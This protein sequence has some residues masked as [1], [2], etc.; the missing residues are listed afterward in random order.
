MLSLAVEWQAAHSRKDHGQRA[1]L[2]RAIERQPLHG[3][4]W[5]TVLLMM[6]H[7][8][9]GSPDRDDHKLPLEVDMDQC[10]AAEATEQ[11]PHRRGPHLLLDRA[12]RPSEDVRTHR[13]HAKARCVGPYQG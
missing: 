3:R 1:S 2:A 7:T 11:D 12:A 6:H 9:W 5:D 8:A 4:P 13:R 10:G